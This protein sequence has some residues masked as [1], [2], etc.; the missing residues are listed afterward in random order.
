M[1]L[2]CLILALPCALTSRRS[3]SDIEDLKIVPVH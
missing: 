3:E 2:S 1:E